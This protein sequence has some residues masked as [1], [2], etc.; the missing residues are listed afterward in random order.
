MNEL[1]SVRID[2]RSG[3]L[4]APDARALA[5]RPVPHP[6][7]F[8]RLFYAIE[9]L[10]V[11]H[12]DGM[13]VQFI[14]PH[15]G[16]GVSTIAAGYAR[17]A[18]SERTRPVLHVDCG[19]PDRATGEAAPALVTGSLG[20][21]GGT[22]ALVPIDV[23]AAPCWVDGVNNLMTVR[24]SSSAHPLLDIGSSR[25][26]PLM[27]S[28]R[29]E[30][31]VVV[32]DCPAATDADAAALGRHADGTV[33]VAA[34]GRTRAADLAAT[35]GEIERFGGQMIGVVFNRTRR[36]VPWWLEWLP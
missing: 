15:R 7:V 5:R 16:A 35:R 1:T 10:R 13:V 23:A 4:A 27:A 31:S 21:P 32:L 11:G 6:D 28:L 3:A 25:I 26:A 33:L 29:R 22:R 2:R 19:P 36:A 9:A 34:A 8:V 20:E 14:A 24:L 18:A 12:E 30:F 17:V